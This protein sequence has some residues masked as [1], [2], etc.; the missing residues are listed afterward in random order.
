MSSSG[1]LLPSVCPLDCPDRCTLE[2]EVTEGRI[3]KIRAGTGNPATA[4]FVCNKVA[5]FGERVH[6]PDRLLHP[7]RRSGKKGAGR[8]ERISWDEAIGEITDR[9]LSIRAR[10]GGE[11]ILPLC[12]GGSNGLLSHGAV[13]FRYFRMLGASRLLRTVCAAATGLAQG[14]VYGKM[15]GVDFAD[16]PAAR[17]IVIWGANPKGSNIHLLRPLAEARRAGARIVQI[18]PRRTLSDVD[19]HLAVRPGTD[20]P[21]ALGL[22]AELE[23]IGAVDRRFLETHARPGWERL[24]ERARPWSPERTEEVTGVAATDLRRLA[25]WWAESDPSLV[26][27]GWGPERNRNGESAVAAILALPA[28]TGK[29]GRPGAGFALATSGAYRVDDE[30]KIGLAAPSGVRR[31]NMSQLGRALTETNDP[32]VAALFVYDANPV[33]TVPDSLRIERGLARE[34][35]FTVVHEQVMT[36]TAKWADLLLPAT[37]F[38]EHRELSR[39]YGCCGLQLS[40]PVIPPVGEAMPN[41]ELFSRLG[42]GA[43]SRLALSPAGFD[44]DPDARLDA[45]LAAIEGPL[46]RPLTRERLAAERWIPFDFPGERPIP[47]VNVFPGTSDGRIDLFPEALG[48]DRFVYEE[49]KE[50]PRF[51][52]AFISPASHRTITSTCAEYN[53]PEGRLEISPADA[54]ARGIADGDLVRIH[55][56]LGEIRCRASISP[57]IRPGVVALPKGLWKKGTANGVVSTA[58][59]PDRVTKMVG[60]ACY[61]DARVEVER[62]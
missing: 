14:S 62:G 15:P 51:P 19:L 58:L 38:L 44:L 30:R 10:L 35:L 41:D 59:V 42:R 25:A 1:T 43:A 33:V 39:S 6:G 32:P 37:T 45:V 40:E 61:N 55:N 8:F 56:D 12:Y 53:L 26:R 9:L 36:D 31:I 2:V 46:S 5:R 34:D 7:M 24:L 54:L 11:A 22:F 20:L 3:G 48:P 47:F 13:D 50:D 17:L 49:P 60:A 28:L 18:D 16:F 52:L 27:C 57:S 4:G 29:F 23:R 21:L